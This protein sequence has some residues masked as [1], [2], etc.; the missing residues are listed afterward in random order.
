MEESDPHVVMGGERLR[1]K[2]N[3][4]H[5]SYALRCCQDALFWVQRAAVDNAEKRDTED[6]L[7]CAIHGLTRLAPN[8]IKEGPVPYPT[9]PFGD[10]GKRGGEDCG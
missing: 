10:G 9:A 7:L 4:D 6:H 8:G 3:A 1:R 5:L 2:M